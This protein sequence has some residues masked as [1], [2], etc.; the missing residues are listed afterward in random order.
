MRVGALGQCVHSGCGL[1]VGHDWMAVC[2]QSDV[3]AALLA[4]LPRPPP[5]C[6]GGL[7][8]QRPA[9]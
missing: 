8:L 1:T 4:G 3:V 2:N 5:F 7:Q 6:P 9:R